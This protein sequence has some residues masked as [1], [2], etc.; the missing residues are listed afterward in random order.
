[1]QRTCSYQS[2]KGVDSVIRESTIEEM[3]KRSVDEA[4]EKT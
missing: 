3:I 1:M 4:Y 2:S